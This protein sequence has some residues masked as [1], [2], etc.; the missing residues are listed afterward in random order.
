VGVVAASVLVVET[1]LVV[2]E[3][4]LARPVWAASDPL[5]QEYYDTEWGMPVRDEQGLFERLSLEAF[6]SGL[7]WATILRKRPGFRAAFDGFDPDR[8][9]D[10]DEADVERLMADPGIV[11]NRRKIDA[12]I[13]NARATVAL[14]ADGGLAELV[15]SFRPTETPAPSTYAEVPTTSPESVALSKELKRRGFTFV[16]PTTMFALMEAVG[17]VDT[18]LVGSHRRGSS[19]VWA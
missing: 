10:Y 11:R 1:A 7:S 15:W 18:H 14:R 9:A 4:G 13:T 16:G 8:V 2:G 12:T 5:L 19:G 17:I 3:D 6:Q